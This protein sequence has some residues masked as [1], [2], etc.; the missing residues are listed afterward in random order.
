MLR[1]PLFAFVLIGAFATPAFGQ[2]ALFDLMH[3]P[4]IAGTYVVG[5]WHALPAFEIE[6]YGVEISDA[7]NGAP[8]NFAARV[9]AGTV[10]DLA[11]EKYDVF[12]IGIAHH[13]R[14]GNG[15]LSFRMGAEFT[16]ADL[17]EGT[18]NEYALPFGFSASTDLLHLGIRLTP[19]VGLGASA[20]Y[21]TIEEEIKV[22]NDGMVGL[23]VAHQKIV[24]G[25]LLKHHFTADQQ[26]EWFLRYRF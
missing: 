9:V 21:N 19:L 18:F 14:L 10:R 25:V 22:R 12:G 26:F 4:A 5:D 20:Y 3:R 8:G 6:A 2:T 23:G 15:P 16:R 1:K 24:A 11:E 13:R 17:A 7:R